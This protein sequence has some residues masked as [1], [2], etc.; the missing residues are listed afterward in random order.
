MFLKSLVNFVSRQIS[1]P[2]L[3]NVRL[4]YGSS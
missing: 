3:Q 1:T 2:A 4:I